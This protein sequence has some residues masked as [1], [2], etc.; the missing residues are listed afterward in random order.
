M[1]YYD[2]NFRKNLLEL[3]SSCR[4]MLRQVELSST[5]KE[6]N[7]FIT[8]MIKKVDEAYKIV[9]PSPFDFLSERKIEKLQTDRFLQQKLENVRQ[10]V[11]NELREKIQK[12]MLQQYKEKLTEE[13]REQLT[14]EIRA[15]LT[16]IIKEECKQERK[17]KKA[18]KRAKT[19]ELIQNEILNISPETQTTSSG[20][21]LQ[22]NIEIDNIESDTDEDEFDVAPEPDIDNI[23]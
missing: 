11:A 4:K 21:N 1:N 10:D 22:Q 14:K 3:L 13:I 5:D 6:Y 19:L 8:D 2:S 15:E 18:R 9:S 23:E 16:P 7:F 20:K 17:L 12:E